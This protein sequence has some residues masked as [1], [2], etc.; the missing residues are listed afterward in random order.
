MTL[1]DEW[2]SGRCAIV[3]R[4]N[5]GK[6]TLL[7]RLLGQKLAIATP[8]P[9]TTR[10]AV[11]G[12]HLSESPPTQVAFVDTPGLAQPKTALHR[13]LVDQATAGLADIDV[14]VLMVEPVRNDG[15]SPVHPGD[16]VVLQFLQEVRAPVI[17]AINKVDTL[18][19]KKTLLPQIAAYSELREFAA[20]V[21][22]SATKPIQL[23]ELLAEIR[24]HLP[25]GKLYDDDTLTDRPERFFVAELV[26]ESVIRR[27][28]QEV[29]Y[30]VA[31]T[32]EKFEQDRAITRIHAAII[33]E[34]PSHKGIVVG[35][36]GTTIKEIGTEARRAISEFLETKV[37]L[38]LWVKVVEGWT[39]NADLARRLV[40]EM[41]Q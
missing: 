40:T 33:V 9:G 7:N 15:R 11:L 39:A 28:R 31:V 18:A 41:Q 24:K 4:P 13:L 8:R 30:G 26:R 38:E 5:V 17:L 19:D 23:N 14:A 35:R 20:I 29:P 10:C 22:I 21:P 27:A 6:S 37:H 34:K 12:V 32:I 16:A 36:K 3:G 2:R 1:E 25:P